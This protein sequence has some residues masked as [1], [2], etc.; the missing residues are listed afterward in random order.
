LLLCSLLPATVFSA[1]CLGAEKVI[2]EVR[3]AE[4]STDTPTSPGAA[5]QARIDLVR[6]VASFGK[7]VD[8]LPP[9]EAAEKW[10]GLFDRLWELPSVDNADP[11]DRIALSEVG[12]AGFNAEGIL[13][14]LPGP[15]AWPHMAR[16][17]EKRSATEKKHPVAVLALCFFTHYLT[18]ETE[19]QNQDLQALDV[20][21]KGSNRFSGSYYSSHLKELRSRLG[22][23]STDDSGTSLADQFDKLLDVAA[24]A[25]RGMEN[26]LVIRVPDLEN[27]GGEAR[28]RTLLAKAL[29]IPGVR[30]T[31][32]QGG[33]T[34]KLAQ[35]IALESLPGLKTPQWELAH[36]LDATS[37]YEAMSRRFPR[38]GDKGDEEANSGSAF[39]RTIA[40][41]FGVTESLDRGSNT[42]REETETADAYYILGL[43]AQGKQAEAF[44]FARKRRSSVTSSYSLRGIMFRVEDKVKPAVLFDFL[45]SLIEK[46]PADH[47]SLLDPCIDLA[48]MVKGTDPA[49]DLFDR[50]IRE[51]GLS[52]AKRIQFQDNLVKLH[53]RT[54]RVD[55]AVSITRQILNAPLRAGEEP[56]GGRDDKVRLL[57]T[58]ERLARVGKLLGRDDWMDEG[59]AAYERL[60]D[61]DSARPF[62]IGNM[63]DLLVETGRFD[64]AEKWLT[65]SLVAAVRSQGPG[66]GYGIEEILRRLVLLYGKAGRPKDV[67]ILI[68]RAPWWNGSDLFRTRNYFSDKGVLEKT[69]A[70]A[71]ADAGRK[72]EAVRLLKEILYEKPSQDPCYEALCEIVGT[73]LIPW[74][75]E[76]Y[77]RDRFEERPLI[78]KAKLLADKGNLDDAEAV[79]RDALK[80]DPTDGEQPAGDRVRAYGVLADVL[81]KKGKQEDALFFRQVV[82]SVRAG[83]LGDD[84]SGADLWKRSLSTYEVARD[85][86]ADAYC[87]QWRL[88]KKYYEQGNMPA[89]EEH[90]RIALEQM[91]GQFGE[92]ASLCFGCEGAFSLAR[93]Q[94]IAERVLLQAA[95]LQPRKPQ[96][97]F[98]LGQL[99]EEQSRYAEAAEYYRK[100]VELDPNYL[101]GLKELAGIAE[102]AFLPVKEREAIYLRLVKLDPLQRHF[103]EGVLDFFPDPRKLWDACK[104]NL[105]FARTVREPVLELSASARR[106][107]EEKDKARRGGR[108]AMFQGAYASSFTDQVREDRVLTPRQAVISKSPAQMIS[109]L[110]DADLSLGI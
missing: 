61:A 14:I 53:L 96:I 78:W 39:I 65:K 97:P 33:A 93:F 72:D 91:P 13:K 1:P 4:A 82:E 81:G 2:E 5:V 100:A 104:D 94:P 57:A 20:A 28:A 58:A 84:L 25:D 37:F 79:I 45:C 69:V 75:D 34:L 38:D 107:E 30:L 10:L 67:V 18:G 110:L 102:E 62:D 106:I 9:D 77:E 15:D 47:V 48:C 60:R 42:D 8:D 87:V 99:R 50:V 89:A 12:A 70:M 51:P 86:F 22:P 26:R 73:D 6:D 17:L 88:A 90:Y 68:D 98:L 23:V 54:N 36:S 85:K 35:R 56:G 76:L 101:D 46:H 74:L 103:H 95:K 41:G 3:K 55:E 64:K 19:K 71:L 63:V 21:L 27:L 109:W 49:I 66:S 80:V 105:K 52:H 83:E 31:V 7:T 29:T 16:L 32:P 92:L 108:D 43:L 40:A 24:G 44:A 11:A 59:I